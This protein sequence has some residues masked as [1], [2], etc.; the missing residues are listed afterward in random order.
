MQALLSNLHLPL[1][2]GRI[3]ASTVQMASWLRALAA[4]AEDLLLVPSTQDGQFTT[5]CNSSSREP[6]PSSGLCGHLHV[7]IHST[8]KLMQAP[9]HTQIINGSFRMSRK[10]R[11][12]NI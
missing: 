7:H 10:T 5:I 3:I 6:I 8:H 11:Q 12:L 4:L 2:V 1:E 9:T